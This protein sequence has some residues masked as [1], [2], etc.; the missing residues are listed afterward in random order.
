MGETLTVTAADDSIGNRGQKST[1]TRNLAKP[2]SHAP[3]RKR[4]MI[5]EGS[6]AMSEYSYTVLF[7]PAE[8]GG[9][10]VTCPALP[11]LVTEGDS[12]EEARSMARDAILGYLESLRQDHR[13]IS[14]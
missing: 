2:S 14:A 1:I 8:K 4:R 6:I 3:K 12:L 10:V 5:E 13:P 11:G 7:E 9:F